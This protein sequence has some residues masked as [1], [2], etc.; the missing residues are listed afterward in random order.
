V[1]KVCSA[2]IAEEV[3]KRGSLTLVCGAVRESEG[4]Y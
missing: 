3:E 4:K 2:R 1:L